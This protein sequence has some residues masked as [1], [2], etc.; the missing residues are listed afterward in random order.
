MKRF[1]P[2][3]QRL[4]TNPTLEELEDVFTVG[5]VTDEFF[6]EY[7][8]RFDELTKALKSICQSDDKVQDEFSRL[9]IETEDFTKKLLGQIV[10]L[11][12][13]QKKG[14]LG[15]AGDQQWVTDP[16]TFMKNLSLT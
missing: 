4:D 5:K 2:L 3:I 11:Y 9:D 16:G 1:S 7:K 6:D 8:K 15:V 14:W 10:F 12:F 13:L